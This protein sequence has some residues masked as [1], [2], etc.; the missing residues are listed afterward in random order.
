MEDIDKNGDG[1]IDLEEYIGEGSGLT[2]HQ[3]G[4]LGWVLGRNSSPKGLGGVGRLPK[5]VAESSA[6]EG[7]R[8]C[9]RFRVFRVVG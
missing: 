3:G 4:G 8:K 6:L 7:F 9:L 2:L 1:F 5:G